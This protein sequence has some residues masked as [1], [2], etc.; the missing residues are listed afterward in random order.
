MKQFWVRLSTRI[1]ALSLRER[2]MLF[3]AVLAAVVFLSYWMILSPLFARQEI[4]AENVARQQKTLADIETQ[5]GAVATRSSF[6][7]DAVNRAR[8]A[9]LQG[10]VRQS[11]SDLRSMQESLVEPERIA[12]LLET[13]LASNGKLKLVSLRTLPVTGLSEALPT[14]DPAAAQAESVAPP[15]AVLS[16]E[17][18]AEAWVAKA[19]AAPAR[20]DGQVTP[21]PELKLPELVYRHGVELTLE[22]RYVDMVNYMSQLESMPVRLIWGRARLDASGHPRTRLTLTLFTLSLEKDWMKL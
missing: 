20:P 18:M 4:L 10:E 7:P 17:K 21:G 12:R 6:D 13:I 22:G 15:Q 2:I 9:T 19:A 3:A 11:S 14:G 5:I 8:L 1:D 16:P